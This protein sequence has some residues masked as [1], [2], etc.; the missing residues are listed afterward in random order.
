MVWERKAFSFRFSK[1]WD[2]SSTSSS[3][4]RCESGSEK[5][6][7]RT[8][9]LC[10]RCYCCSS[11]T[12]CCRGC[13]T[14]YSNSIHWKIKRGGGSNQNP[15]CFL[16]LPGMLLNKLTFLPQLDLMGWTSK[17]VRV[18]K[19]WDKDLYLIYFLGWKVS[20]TCL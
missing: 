5:W 3:L 20:N 13:S 15:D 19:I 8:C 1:S 7:D 2:Y 10:C 12:G 9:L 18:E 6:A 17:F 14:Y 4:G 16:W 11:C